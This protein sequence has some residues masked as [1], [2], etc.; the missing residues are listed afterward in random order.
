MKKLTAILIASV[1]LAGVTPALAQSGSYPDK[2]IRLIVPFPPGGTADLIGRITAEAL[3]RELGQ[4]VIV[5]NVAGAG[6]STGFSH[7]ARAEPDGYTLGLGT[8]STNGT[9]SAVYST[10]PY[11]AITDF[12]PITKLISA[13]AVIAVNP[14]FPAQD[15][16]AFVSL[17]EENP[18]EYTYASSGTGGATHLGMEYFKSLTGLDI[19]HIP[20]QGS[21]P[22]LVDVMGGHVPMIWDTLASSF[23]H[24]ESGSIVP[25][26]VAFPERSAQL[27]DVPTFAE[28]G[29]EDYD[30]D[31]WNGLLAPAGLPDDILEIIHEAVVR[32]INDPSSKTKIEAVG[33]VVVGN[34]PEEFAEQIEADVAKWTAVAEFADVSLD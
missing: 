22:A 24:I 21:G 3:T 20:Y 27:P 17:I 16:E 10:L 6:G 26:A 29:L 2:P 30:P 33:A 18:G 28:M 15:Y 4:N 23:Q 7:L 14:S 31:L 12:T 13:P 25:I 1:A 32:G 34:S 8:S 5:E 19:E 9:N 11:D